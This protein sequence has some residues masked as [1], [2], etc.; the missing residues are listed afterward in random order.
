MLLSE[1]AASAKRR[2]R[3]NLAQVPPLTGSLDKS[4]PG[5]GVHVGCVGVL[6]AVGVSVAVVGW[7]VVVGGALVW[8]GVSL[9][10]ALLEASWIRQASHG[11]VP[12]G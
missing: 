10:S 11:K 6:G 12:L 8:A 4:S 3:L 1:A 7:C 5:R 2:T 9:A